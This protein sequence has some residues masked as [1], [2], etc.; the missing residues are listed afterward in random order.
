MYRIFESVSGSQIDTTLDR[1]FCSQHG[2]LCCV[3]QLL[4]VISDQYMQL[5]QP[6][7]NERIVYAATADMTAID[8]ERVGLIGSEDDHKSFA[9][10]NVL[11]SMHDIRYSGLVTHAIVLRRLQDQNEFAIVG[12]CLIGPRV[13]GGHIEDD[14]DRSRIKPFTS[15]ICLR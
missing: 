7:C 10:G 6:N 1:V 12:T 14:V 13:I 8:T 2:T 9:S 3:V 5:H 11:C 15:A 4:G